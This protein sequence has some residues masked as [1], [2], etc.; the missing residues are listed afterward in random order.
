[1]NQQSI[2]LVEDSPDDV[3]LTLRAF[4]KNNMLNE[5]FVARDGVQAIEFL[6]GKEGEKDPNPGPLPGLVLL[7]LN[8]PL[9]NGIEVLKRIRSEERTRLLRVVVMTSSREEKDLVDSYH[10]GATSYIRKP[11]DFNQFIEAVRQLG[12]YWLV[13]NEAPPAGVAKP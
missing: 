10:Y 5:V 11:V 2:L 8:L 7:D 3:D 6:L 12:M 13:L 1:M 9:I 4:K